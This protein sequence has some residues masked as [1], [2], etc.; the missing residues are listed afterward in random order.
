MISKRNKLILKIADPVDFGQRFCE[1]GPRKVIRGHT[2]KLNTL[3]LYRIS[4]NLE[5]HQPDVRIIILLLLYTFYIN[6]FATFFVVFKFWPCAEK[7]QNIGL[8]VA[9]L[10]CYFGLCD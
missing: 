2:H 6:S 7:G 5:I 4:R 8:P 10:H 1:S 3:A 9:G